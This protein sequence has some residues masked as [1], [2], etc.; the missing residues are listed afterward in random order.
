MPPKPTVPTN[1]DLEV[2][3][4][5]THEH[6]TTSVQQLR[7]ET[8]ERFLSINT[9]MENQLH[10]LHSKL[11]EQQQ[12]QQLRSDSQDARFDS[13]SA[14]ILELMQQML[15]Q[16]PTIT[17][18]P[19]ITTSGTTPIPITSPIPVVSTP[20]VTAITAILTKTLAIPTTISTI[21][22]ILTHNTTI[23][24]PPPISSSL[25]NSSQLFTPFSSSSITTA[26]F[27][28]AT[29]TTHIPLFSQAT[30]YSSFPPPPPYPPTS[31]TLQL[32]LLYTSTNFSIRTLHRIPFSTTPIPILHS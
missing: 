24:I 2:A 23:P 4:Q 26:P 15:R 5:E 18:S 6:I 13:I 11:D 30:R 12:N 32:Q 16:Q 8:D 1:K 31:F 7:T 27:C 14:Q 10:L 17:S 19:S 29:T 28:F 3:V 22:T 21:N 20:R 9:N 25:T